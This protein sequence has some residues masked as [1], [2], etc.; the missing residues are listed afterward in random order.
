[1]S[2]AGTKNNSEVTAD[3]YPSF[4]LDNDAASMF[5]S[6][7]LN[8]LRTAGTRLK[9]GYRAAYQGS[10]TNDFTLIEKLIRGGFDRLRDT[11]KSG[12]TSES[13]ASSSAAEEKVDGGIKL[14]NIDVAAASG[15]STIEFAAVGPEFFDNLT[16]TILA[17]NDV[18]SVAE[19]VQ[20]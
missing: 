11:D 16:F 19:F 20:V 17:T 4:G 6:E 14:D 1:L 9:S 18:S 12:K 8:R 2:I 15:S 7:V 3:L 10:D 5:I 13:S